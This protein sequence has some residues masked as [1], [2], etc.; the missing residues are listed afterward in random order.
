MWCAILDVSKTGILGPE[1][2]HFISPFEL[3]GRMP[4]GGGPAR[5]AKGI[6]LCRKPRRTGQMVW[7]GGRR[8]DC[9]P[10]Q[11]LENWLVMKLALASR[12]TVAALAR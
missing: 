8:R 5:T 7:Q 1:R 10:H 2:V 12:D 11:G 9:I 3:V 4:W 6:W